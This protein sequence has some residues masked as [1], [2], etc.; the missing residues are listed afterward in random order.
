MATRRRNA[1]VPDMSGSG[2]T[3]QFL[4]NIAKA[5]LLNG[6]LIQVTNVQPSATTDVA[7]GLGRRFQ[8]FFMVQPATEAG[9]IV[10]AAPTQTDG[11]KYVTIVTSAVAAVDFQLFVF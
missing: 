2:R 5:P 1:L 9:L 6:N 11:T 4:V 7:H 3:E 10:T 8:G